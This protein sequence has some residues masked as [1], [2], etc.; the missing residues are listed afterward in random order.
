MPL[1][2]ALVLF[3]ALSLCF[4]YGS[5]VA[6]NPELLQLRTLRELCWALLV[7]QF[8]SQDQRRRLRLVLLCRQA[9]VARRALRY[10][11]PAAPAQ[12]QRAALCDSC[13]AKTGARRFPL[14]SRQE[15]EAAW[16]R[17]EISPAD[18]FRLGMIS[19]H[20]LREQLPPLAVQLSGREEPGG[21]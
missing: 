20:E 10:Q 3:L 12:K 4:T 5:A 17:A 16:R 13:R 2:P 19:K 21:S 18:Q 11:V 7:L 1:V 15:I 14:P 8:G 6:G 9:A